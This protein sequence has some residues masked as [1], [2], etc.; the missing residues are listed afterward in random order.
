MSSP[1]RGKA[2]S[3]SSPSGAK[4]GSAPSSPT[5]KGGAPSSPSGGKGALGSP[6]GVKSAQ[7][8]FQRVLPP[9][10]ARYQVVLLPSFIHQRYRLHTLSPSDLP[11][12]R[13]L[14]RSVPPFPSS[15]PPS[16]LSLFHVLT[17]G[18][19]NTSGPVRCDGRQAFAHMENI[20]IYMYATG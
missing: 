9:Q 14:N 16:L 18:A 7:Q 17:A 1:Q 12:P 15:S 10:H 3:I 5:G 19:Q 2:G 11:I 13:S 20:Y 6:S 8:T 4:G